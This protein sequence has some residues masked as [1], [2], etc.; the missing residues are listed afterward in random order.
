MG[1]KSPDTP[2]VEGAA[3]TEGEFSRDTARDVTYADR[4]DQT[5]P[6][7]S[8]KWGTQQVLD[9]ATGEM[10]TKWSQNQSLD[11]RLQSTLDSSLGMMGGNARLGQDMA[12]RIASEMAPA[13][14]WGQFGGV[15]GFNP[16]ERRQ[17]AEDAAY[18]KATH[19]MDSRFAGDRDALD[20]RL[21]NQGL[22]P[23]DQGYQA[24]METFNQGKNDAYERARFDSVAQGR[25]EYGIS[26]QG[27][28]RANALRDKQIQEYIDKR[29]FSLNEQKK[30]TEGQT[31]SDI[32]QLVAGG[33]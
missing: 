29:G 28:E 14:N 15:E 23:G 26:L 25:D 24:Q 5:N 21:R 4:P 16:E 31:A 32:G 8:V 19:R 12:G 9:P 22:A 17:Q 20:I 13:P 11:P 27:N 2:D 7:G 6:F 1:K 10:V 33:S 3:R 18:G 30:L